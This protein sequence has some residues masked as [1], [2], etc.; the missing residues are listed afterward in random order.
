MIKQNCHDELDPRTT[1]SGDYEKHEC[2]I[3]I[4]SVQLRDAGSWSCE[5]INTELTLT[6]DM[7]KS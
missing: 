3:T 5:V 7:L 1:Y 4:S 6:T 2:S